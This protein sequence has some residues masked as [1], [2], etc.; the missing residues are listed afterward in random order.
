MLQLKTLLLTDTAVN[1]PQG[2]P[3]EGV[4][5][6]TSSL[7]ANGQGSCTSPSTPSDCT[8]LAQ[9]HQDLFMWHP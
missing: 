5:G 8:P 6:E 7:W 9:Q 3:G 4:G 2:L 1:R